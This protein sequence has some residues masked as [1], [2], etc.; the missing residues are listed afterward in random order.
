MPSHVH[1]PPVFKPL[2]DP[3]LQIKLAATAITGLSVGQT[4]EARVLERLEDGRFIIRIGA[5][6]LTAEAE[7]TLQAGADDDAPGRQ[8]EPQGP[9]VGRV[10][11]RRAHYRRAPAGFPVQ[12]RRAH[13]EPWRAG[14]DRR[15]HPG[16]RP[17]PPRGP[18]QSGGDPRC[19]GIGHAGSGADRK[20]LFAARCRPVPGAACSR[21]I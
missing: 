11:A 21:A 7:P 12:P 2:I 6:H 8:P 5:S 9:A 13:A 16:R 4:V 19:A 20:G 1:F 10:P 14:R 15:R 17:L 3:V 18:R